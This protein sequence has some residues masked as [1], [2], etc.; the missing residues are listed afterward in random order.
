EDPVVCL[1]EHIHHQG[2][3]TLVNL[4]I[5]HQVLQVWL[6]GHLEAH[7]VDQVFVCP[8]GTHREDLRGHTHRDIHHKGDSM[9]VGTLP[10][11]SLK[12]TQ[13]GPLLLQHQGSKDT[14]L[15]LQH[16]HHQV[17]LGILLVL[18]QVA[19]EPLPL[20]RLVGVQVHS[21]MVSSLVLALL[22]LLQAALLLHTPAQQLPTL[23]LLRP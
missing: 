18:S 11:M 7:Q 3:V 10:R 16:L 5:G 6:V 17:I 23:P 1:Q 20:H 15:H 22:H 8:M 19:Q 9:V 14:G 2:Q 21:Q 12:A 4:V 13:V